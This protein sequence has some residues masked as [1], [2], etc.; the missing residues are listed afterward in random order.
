VPEKVMLLGD[1]D[2]AL[3]S[4]IADAHVCTEQLEIAQ[5]ILVESCQLFEQGAALRPVHCDQA[6]F[7]I[8]TLHAPVQRLSAS[9]RQVDRFPSD[10]TLHRHSLLA[11][12]SFAD[13]QACSVVPMIVQLRPICRDSSF[14]VRQH[15]I[16]IVQRM[17]RL[18]QVSDTIPSRIAE[19]L[20]RAWAVVG[21]K[22]TVAL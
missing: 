18:L 16:A 19:L 8:N 11:V 5:H 22:V 3:S 9:L 2:L 1:E 13:E 6:L 10:V 17:E 7:A 12:L 15:C 4:L 21:T 20:E 14:Q